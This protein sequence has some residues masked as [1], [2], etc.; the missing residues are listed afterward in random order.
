MRHNFAEYLATKNKVQPLA[1]I[2]IIIVII[3]FIIDQN[4]YSYLTP[5]S[6]CILNNIWYLKIKYVPNVRIYLNIV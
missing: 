1:I 2:T 4:P 6:I 5:N 3:I